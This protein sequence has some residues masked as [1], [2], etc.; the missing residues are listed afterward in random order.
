MGKL[1]P[2]HSRTMGIRGQRH[3]QYHLRLS[4]QHH[5][6]SE[7]DSSRN[8]MTIA[9]IKKEESKA[10]N[11]EKNGGDAAASVSASSTMFSSWRIFS[12]KKRE[13]KHRRS[14]SLPSSASVDSIP[15]CPGNDEEGDS[16]HDEHHN[17][18]D[19][20]H[21]DDSASPSSSVVSFGSCEIRTYS[22][23]LGDHPCC[24]EGCPIE[25]GW[26]YSD[27]V[28]IDIDEYE[29]M[30]TESS[31]RRAAD[32]VSFQF[33]DETVV[34]P[35]DSDSDE[36]DDRERD[37][38]GGGDHG[39]PIV[40][41]LPSAGLIACPSYSLRLSPEERKEILM[42]QMR[43]RQQGQQSTTGDVDDDNNTSYTERDL[44][45]ECRRLNRYKGKGS[46]CSNGSS[47]HKNF[48]KK[49][50]LFFGTPY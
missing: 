11:D 4:Q 37:H 26:D 50:K 29:N 28:S 19:E 22:Q 15:T 3:R 43:R 16:S 31:T 42:K 9:T 23:V 14:R 38:D 48:V 36:D 2:N 35:N 12:K 32:L 45:R 13:R 39:N 44:L 20:A 27:E 24:L 41:H 49:Q 6:N 40:L 1:N 17:H 33:V 18:L 30:K 47:S 25:L 21:G 46:W 7:S 5:T 10:E 34:A 8:K